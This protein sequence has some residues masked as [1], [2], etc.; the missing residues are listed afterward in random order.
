MIFYVMHT[1]MK[2]YKIWTFSLLVLLVI[3]IAANYLIWKLY[4]EDILT[5]KPW[6]NG[7]LD[8]LG[9]IPG[10]KHY[11]KPESILPKKHIDNVDYAGQHIDVLTIGD[12]FSNMDGNGRDPL[13]QD[14]IAST[15]GLEVL[16]I[17]QLNNMDSLTTLIVLLN[18]GYLDKI[19]PKHIIFESVERGI[20]YTYA[21]DIDFTRTAPLDEIIKYY[22]TAK[23]GNESPPPFFI[24]NGNFK[25]LLY[26][27]LYKVSDHAYNSVVYIRDLN[28]RAFSV[29]QYENKLLFINADL[30]IIPLTTPE[31]IQLFNSNLNKLARLLRKKGMNLY[32]MPAADKYNIY[33]DYIIDNPYP[34]S[35][36]YELLR[37]KPK[38]YIFVDTKTL[39]QEEVRKGEIDVYYA[40][41]THWSWKGS[42]KIVEHMQF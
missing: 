16:N 10:A 20:L 37:N 23:F 26:R 14:W 12:S 17:Q 15:H 13:Y 32:F 40:D 28:I 11:R 36:F 25:F 41:D 42:K 8:R 9:Y 29:P 35:I 4:T 38:A 19:R 39:L 3:F 2:A 7:G 33:S 22:R 31:K 34:K 18:S 6:H 1:K 5:F 24:N 27:L 21:K 30:Q